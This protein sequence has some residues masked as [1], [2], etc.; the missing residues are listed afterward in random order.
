MQV[1]TTKADIRVRTIMRCESLPTRF[2]V[3]AAHSKGVI[4]II[5]TKHNM[6]NRPRIPMG[7]DMTFPPETE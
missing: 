4:S 1:K 2:G 3:I 6:T 5:G 7:S